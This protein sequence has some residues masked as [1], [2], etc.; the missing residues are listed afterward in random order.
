M[1]KNGG[2]YFGSGGKWCCLSIVAFFFCGLAMRFNLDLYNWLY[3]DNVSKMF[4]E[5]Q[6]VQVDRT[7][8]VDERGEDGDDN[9]GDILAKGSG[10]SYDMEPVAP[11]INFD[12]DSESR[13]G[14]DND[15]D[16]DNDNDN[17]ND[18]DYS[19]AN[20]NVVGEE[21][22]SREFEMV[23]LDDDNTKDVL[24]NFEDSENQDW[25]KFKRE[26]GDSSARSLA[27]FLEARA[28][29]HKPSQHLA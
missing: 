1:C 2:C 8:L 18:N 17:D 21:N 23:S 28:E 22:S 5:D 3:K 12:F 15:N 16:V 10:Q 4:E 25:S 13:D 24:K 6:G 7:P 20:M 29:S 14:N 27:S 9:E 26:L 11:T 19:G